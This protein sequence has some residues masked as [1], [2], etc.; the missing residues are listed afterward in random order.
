MRAADDEKANTFGE[1]IRNKENII[2][3]LKLNY[4]SGKDDCP[5]D[6][7]KKLSLTVNIMC[8][9]DKDAFGNNDPRFDSFSGDSCDIEIN[10]TSV[11]GCPVFSFDALHIFLEKYSILWGAVMILAGL[12]LA[13]V[14]NKFVSAVIFMA[15]AFCAWALGVTLIFYCLTKSNTE[16]EDWVN[17]V[18]LGG[19][20]LI[21][22][23]AGYGLMKARKYGIALLAIWGGVMIGLLLTSSFFIE[24]KA[25]YWCIV[26]GCGL[27]VGVFAFFAEEIVIC[28]AT[29][30]IGSYAVIRGI[31]LY[32][33]DFPAEGSLQDMIK[34]GALTWDTFPKAFFAY[35]AGIVVIFVLSFYFQLRNRKKEKLK[36]F[37]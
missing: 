23:L 33:G 20:A 8:P 2:T 34:S 29:A 16:T 26:I 25:L 22:L 4:V 14:G 27:L 13:F 28:G 7:T 15:G 36:S 30:F 35:L 9:P 17:W 24:S 1:E 31:S 18:I 12:F 3:G 37:I 21:A 11:K 10:Y 32:A 19:M 5:S 6:P